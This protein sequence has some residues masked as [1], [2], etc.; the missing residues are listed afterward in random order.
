MQ[1]WSIHKII[2]LSLIYGPLSALTY[3]LITKLSPTNVI[4]ASSLW[5]FLA[6]MILLPFTKIKYIKQEFEGLSSIRPLS[7]A[8]SQVLLLYA[9][10]SNSPYSVFLASACGMVVSLIF[11]RVL[12]N[13]K[14]LKIHVIGIVLCFSG[15]YFFRNNIEYSILGSV[16]GILQGVVVVLS[17]KRTMVGAD[18]IAMV[19][20]SLCALLAMTAMH[21]VFYNRIPIVF[22]YDGLMLALVAVMV[23]LLQSVYIALSSR[24]ES[25][26]LSLVGNLRIPS[27]LIIANTMFSTALIPQQF[28]AGCIVCVGISLMFLGKKF[29]QEIIKKS[30]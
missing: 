19:T 12:L 11:G 29:P 13:E 26:Q 18:K 5:L 14:T 25:W 20:S 3:L 2:L 21:N 22:E 4:E 6:V 24:L 15:I 10:E 9:M 1:N 30:V 7:F 16:A 8:A 17:R 27:S 23:I 28:Y